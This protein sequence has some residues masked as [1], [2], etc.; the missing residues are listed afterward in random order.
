[1][2][3]AGYPI[4][5][6]SVRGLDRRNP[7]RALGAV[8]RAG[9][10]VGTARGL[11]ARLGADAVLGGR[12][13][14]GRSGRAGRGVAPHPARAERGRQPSRPRQPHARAVRAARVP[15]VPDR[16]TRRGAL[17]R[18]GA[19][20]AA[21]G[22]RGRSRHGARAARRSAR[23][24]VRARLRRQHRRSV[25]QPRRGRRADRHARAAH[26]RRARLRGGARAR[27]ASGHGYRVFEYLDS[28]ADPLAACDLVVARAGGSVFEIAAA[29][30]PAILVPYPHA[31]ADHQAKN[32]R[33][34]ADAGAAVVLPDAELDARSGCA[35]RSRRCSATRHGCAD[36]AT[37]RDRVARPDA[38]QRIAE[39][40]LSAAGRPVQR[41]SRRT[42]ERAQAALRGHRRRRDERPR[43][44]RAGARRRGERLRRA[45]RPRTSTSCARPASSRSVGHDASH[46]A[47]GTELVVS[48]AIPADLPEVVARADGAPPRR[49]AGR[50]RGDAPRDR[51]GGH[52]RQDHDHG[53]D[54]PRAGRVR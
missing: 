18:H 28:L 43:A 34:M 39:E 30:T 19:S 35:R 5:Y 54:R 27:R 45:P 50:G 51:G 53:D 48:T 6:L 32:A 47:A 23:C 2:P 8:A 26:H 7:V 14:R 13:I 3:A 1:M 24:T 21:R 31:T 52:A 42:V 25:G 15:R 11:L 22:G 46:A 10:A 36:G 41:A 37:P 12:W 44:D 38:A 49:A 4:E 17:P 20:G 40:V 33:W 29:G 9:S 16:G